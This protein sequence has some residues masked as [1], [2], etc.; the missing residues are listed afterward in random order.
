M[1][2]S[3]KQQD[4]SKALSVVGHAVSTKSTLPILGNILLSTDQGR[5][6]LS[7]T[8][9]EIGITTWIDVEVHQEGTTTVPAKTFSELITSLAS[10]NIDLMVNESHS[11]N[12]KTAKNNANIKSMDPSEYPLIPNADGATTSVT[13]NANTLKEVIG[14]TAFAAATDDSRPVLTGVCIDV[15]DQTM[16]FAAADSFRLAYREITLSSNVE[17]FGNILIPA[18]TLIGLGKILSNDGPVEMIITPNR[19]QVLFHT[20]HIDL[21]SRLIE[22]TFPN[23]RAAIPK[24]HET[25]ITIETKEFASA[26]KA[27]SPFA[28]DSSNI[29]K[30]KANNA[31]TGATLT[32]EAHA[33]DL[34]NNTTTINAVIDGPDTNI[35]FNVK[36]LSD[37][38]GIINTPEVSLLLNTASSPG[39]LRPIGTA[40][41]TYVI[42]P[43]SAAR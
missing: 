31:L 26:I 21:V 1:R 40:D 10:G 37:V 7:S 33:E 22:G 3:C 30:V 13:L 4:L 43:M 8:N 32:L 12:V 17:P 18:K 20:E 42:M 29:V 15:I 39:I 14:Q 11:V 25:K 34:G 16:A 38:L 9:L 2:I 23:I 19:S 6:K 27:V 35:I 41:Y 28:K 24:H 36:Y 5:L